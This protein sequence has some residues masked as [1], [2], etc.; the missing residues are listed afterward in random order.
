M[1]LRNQLAG[2]PLWRG[3]LAL[4]NVRSFSSKKDVLG[5][6]NSAKGGK[7][8]RMMSGPQRSMIEALEDI[9]SDPGWSANQRTMVDRLFYAPVATTEEQIRDDLKT[10]H[11]LMAKFN[12]DD[13][14]WNHISAR[15]L[16]EQSEDCC[17]LPLDSFLIT[18]GGMHFSEVRADDFVFDTIDECGNI[19]HSGIYKS[20]PDIRSIIH[21]HTPAIMTVSVLKNGFKF[22]TQDSA[23]FFNKIGYHDWEGLHCSEYEKERIAENLGTDGIALFMR[24]HGATV[25][26]RS[27]QEAWVRT[28]YLDRC[29][30]VQLAAMAT[31]DELIECPED[32][33]E[34][35][36]KQ[37]ESFF[38]HGKYE[39]R[40]LTRLVDKFSHTRTF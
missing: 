2:R 19:I 9:E 36:Q 1:L 15:C 32:L 7:L 34:H 29:C 10:A 20:R 16:Y 13:L 18:P 30:Q 22:L 35:A 40:A 27:I 6:V 21:T 24:N 28:Y 5:N 37:V 3:L 8:P 33:L 11:R 14:V 17:D 26:G 31:G 12:Y 38:P 39:W 23:P 4:Q 25:V